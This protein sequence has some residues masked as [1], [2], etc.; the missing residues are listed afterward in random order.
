MLPAKWPS[1]HGES[2]AWPALRFSV[3]R[4]GKRHVGGEEAK[5]GCLAGES[6]PEQTHLLLLSPAADHPESVRYQCFVALLVLLGTSMS[7][8]AAIKT[9]G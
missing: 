9:V 3:G 5:Q 1:I 7:I 4:S 8:P 2:H 6:R